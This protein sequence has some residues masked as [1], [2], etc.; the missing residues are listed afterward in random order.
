[1]APDYILNSLQ[2]EEFVN[3]KPTTKIVW[4]GNKPSIVNFTKSKKGN[5]WQ[6]SELTFQNKRDVLSIK[7]SEQQGIWLAEMLEKLSVYQLKT[8]TIQ[9]VK[10]NYEAASLE[11]FELCGRIRI[12]FIFSTNQREISSI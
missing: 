12:L 1:M 9:E 8:Y 6:M 10:Q 3:S 4:L 11:N 2:Q 5:H 7:V